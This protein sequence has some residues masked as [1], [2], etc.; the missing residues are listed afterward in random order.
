MAT[1][2]LFHIHTKYSFDS[3][4]EPKK[5][6]DFAS[7]S[8][9]RIIAVTDH[10]SFE[11]SLEV[12]K[13]IEKRGLSLIPL[14]GC[15]YS[16][17]SGDVIGLFAP[18]FEYD[19]GVE[20]NLDILD[21]VHKIRKAGGIV[22]LPHP[23]K[24]R[25]PDGQVLISADLIEGYNGRMSPSKNQAAMQIAKEYKK[26]LIG[27]SDAHFVKELGTVVV[28][29]EETINSQMPSWDFLRNL[30]LKSQ[31]E[32]DCQAATV[33]VKYIYL[34][35]VVKIFKT[36]DIFTALVTIARMSLKATRKLLKR[37]FLLKH[38]H[39]VPPASSDKK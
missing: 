10:N 18:D 39:V 8:G 38:M 31:C 15:E 37:I 25:K 29:F 33:K 36:K 3:V 9:F 17:K 7:R 12:K 19:V 24:N 14:Q 26:K 28:T 23:F 13:I 32:I 21:V 6:V 34:S 22:I 16:T 20:P 27:G 1:K 35:F 2:M 4:L 5:I 11:G 30:L